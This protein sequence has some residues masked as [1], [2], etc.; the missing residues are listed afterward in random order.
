M[1]VQ[2]PGDTN[3]DPLPVN[4]SKCRVNLSVYMKWLYIER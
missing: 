1:R 3:I 4:E 2:R